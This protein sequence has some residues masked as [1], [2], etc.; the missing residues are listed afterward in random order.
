ASMPVVLASDQS[1]VS[2]NINQYGGTSTTLGQKA[3]TA[4]MPVVISSDQSNVN[5]ILPDLYITGAANS[6]VGN[7]NLLAV[8]G[9]GELDVTGYKSASVQVISG[10]TSGTFIFEGSN[11]LTSS[12]FQAIP[13]FRLDSASPNAIVTAITAAS[14]NFIYVMPIRYR[15]IRMRVVTVLSAPVIALTRLSQDPF[16]A[17]VVNVVNGT[18]ANLNATISGSLTSAGTVTQPT[19]ANLNCTAL[20]AGATLQ[21]GATTDITSATL[22]AGTV[23]SINVS[24]ANIQASSF[25][26]YVTVIAGTP[27]YDVDVQETMDGT[28]YYTIYSFERITGTGQYYS[29]VIKH[30]GSGLR[31]VRTV[32]G[33]TPSVTSS[34]VRV[35]R[36]GQ[37]ETMRRFINRT[38]VP[39]TLNS[40]TGSYFCDGIEDF[41]L[42]V[43]CTAQTTAAT[44]ALE[45]S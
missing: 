37:A 10:A 28:S 5:T 26:I 23:N 34:V 39:N 35:S 30:S 13:V 4:S 27:T 7:N 14:S 6:A 31:Y 18:A 16:V 22:G 42:I 43:R 45:F 11:S 15:Y 12:H 33:T 20:V 41:N 19:A 29:P 38:I 3:M 40:N 24:T 32:G 1:A 2:T 25:A 9:P 21:A 17:P 44:I 8:A 36:Q